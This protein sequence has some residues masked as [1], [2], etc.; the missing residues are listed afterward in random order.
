MSSLDF[1]RDKRTIE[2]FANDVEDFTEREACWGVILRHDFIEKGKPCSVEEYG[3]D[4]SGRVILGRLPNSNVDKVFN[5]ANGNKR[6]IEIKTIP[7]RVKNFFT[8]K[9]SSLLTCVEQNAYIIVPRS[10][11]YYVLSPDICDYFYKNYPHN[12]YK[13][14]AFGK[15]AVRIY[16]NDIEKLIGENKIIRK[17]WSSGSKKLI[18][19]NYNVL[20][21]QRS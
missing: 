6:L 7:E 4:N 1:R 8:F 11:S 17:Q 2:Q 3:V 16:M 10:C 14:F 18:D 9:I 12:I 21:R 5:F 15:R 19:K 20:F 13:N